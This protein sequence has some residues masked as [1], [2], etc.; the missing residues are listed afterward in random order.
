MTVPEQTPPEG[1]AALEFSSTL[2]HASAL[3]R[4]LADPTRLGIMALLQDGE[5]PVADIAKTLG[6]PLPAVSQHLAKL[7]AGGL[8]TTRREGRTIYYRQ[9]DEHLATLVDNMLLHA[10]H[11]QTD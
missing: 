3:L 8:V 5:M 7:R 1:T 9:V 6:R 2:E 10:A 11:T 4:L